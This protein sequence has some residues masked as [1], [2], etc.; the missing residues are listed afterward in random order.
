MTTAKKAMGLLWGERTSLIHKAMV[1]AFSLDVRARSNGPYL[2]IERAAPSR[3]D[4][5]EQY[6]VRHLFEET[7]VTV[8]E[9]L[10]CDVPTGYIDS[11]AGKIGDTLDPTSSW[12]E[13]RVRSTLEGGDARLYFDA[14]GVVNFDGGPSAFRS[15][16][17]K[18][19]TGQAFLTSCQESSTATY[20]WLER[21]QLFG[22][23]R[24][25]G[26]NE[27]R[28]APEWVLDFSFDLYAAL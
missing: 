23:G 7:T 8:P 19:I 27:G 13:M 26:K 17:A 12:L 22:V 14:T 24:V 28:S 21:R 2:T 9:G 16:Q 5:H 25:E 10:R 15:A 4:D 6:G 3:A 18:T 1:Y 20:R 11:G